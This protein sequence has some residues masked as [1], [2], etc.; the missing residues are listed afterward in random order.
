MKTILI[1]L[2]ALIGY[3]AIGQDAVLFGRR[4][5]QGLSIVC[6]GAI[7]S[8]GTERFESGAGAFCTTGWTETDS[9]SKLDTYNGVQFLTGTKSMRVDLDDA[10]QSVIYANP[11]DDAVSL[12]FYLRV[13]NSAAL[14]AG[15]TVTLLQFDNEATFAGEPIVG[16]DLRVNGDLTTSLRI[17][18]LAA[19]VTYGP[20]LSMN[21]WYRIEVDAARNATSTLRVFS[22]GG[23]QFG[24]DATITAG[25]AA[26]TYLAFGKVAGSSASASMWFDNITIST[27]STFPIGSDE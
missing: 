14:G 16:L 4:K 3:S 5:E 25:D 26:F 20:S 2:A 6:S 13:T 19:S 10:S 23:T 7:L 18:N 11:A 15:N 21:T 12:R 17:K 9:A 22:I 1:F 27:A 8:G 24:T